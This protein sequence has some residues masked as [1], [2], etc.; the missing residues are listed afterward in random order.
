MTG[1]DIVMTGGAPGE[2]SQPP[3][4]VL[5]NASRPDRQTQKGAA[6][7][8]PAHDRPW[9]RSYWIEL[10]ESPIT[11]LLTAQTLTRR[12]MNSRP[13]AITALRS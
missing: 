3:A 5:Q 7:A 9:T 11:H 1:A 6:R 13:F 8:A 4:F 12:W 10:P 2:D